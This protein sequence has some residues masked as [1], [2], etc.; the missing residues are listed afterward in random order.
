[1]THEYILAKHEG[2]GTIPLAAHLQE[3][4][5]AAVVIARN[6]GLNESLAHKGAI[7]HDI[8][9]VSPLFQAQLKNG[10]VR[11]PHFIFRH[12][13]AS[14]F[15][16][17]LLKEE[18]RPEILEMIIAHHKSTLNDVNHKGLLDLD[19]NLRDCFKTHICG[20]QDW[21]IPALEILEITMTMQLI[22][23]GQ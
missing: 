17:S 6:G 12:E 5:A 15:F 23:V 13:I 16:L 19:D 1:M 4:A 20:F 2:M 21:R 14:L 22:I 3:V 10:Y 9:K 11:P 18:E 7:L 8:G